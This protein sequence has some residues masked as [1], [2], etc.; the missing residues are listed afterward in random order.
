MNICFFLIECKGFL[1]LINI[2]KLKLSGPSTPLKQ[3][4]S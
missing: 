1:P 4:G 3:Q 2:I